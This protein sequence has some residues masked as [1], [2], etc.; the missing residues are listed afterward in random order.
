MAVRPLSIAL[1][2]ALVLVCASPVLAC[3]GPKLFIGLPDDP[4]G[5][6]LTSIVAVYVKEKTGIET[7]RVK[8]GSHDAVSQIAADKI[9]YGFTGPATD[10]LVVLLKVEGLP[11]LVSGPRI[12]DDLQFTTVAPALERL[13]RLLTADHVQQAMRRVEA[14]ELPMAAARAYLMELRWI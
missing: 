14:G 4:Q 12:P 10:G 6:L 1:Q 8:I 2:L 5:Q 13:Q 11:L 7:E 9:D 3:F